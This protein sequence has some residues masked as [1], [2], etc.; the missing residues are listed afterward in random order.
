MVNNIVYKRNDGRW[1]KHCP[2]CGIEQ[3]YLRKNYAEASLRENKECK[4][5]SNKRTANCHRGYVGNIR[6]SWFT[7]FKNSAAL[8]GLVFDLTIE[9]VDTMFKKQDFCCALSDMPIGFSSV[10]QG[11]TISIDRIDSSLGYIVNNVQLVHK[12]V[13]MMKQ[14][15]SQKRFVEICKAVADKVKW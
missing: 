1:C 15:Y 8:R 3:D 7:K 12:D 14:A 13:N 4:S 10:G 11:H 6:V 5:C 9:E 2:V